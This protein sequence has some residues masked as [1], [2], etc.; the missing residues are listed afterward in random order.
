MEDRLKDLDIERVE[1][2]PSSKEFTSYVTVTDELAY[3]HAPADERA[4]LLACFENAQEVV[5]PDLLDN[6]AY[7]IAPKA[8]DDCYVITNLQ[9]P[10]CVNIIGENAFDD[11]VNLEYTMS[12]EGLAYIGNTSNPYLVLVKRFSVEQYENGQIEYIASN[13]TSQYTKKFTEYHVHADTKIIY[14]YALSGLDDS[15]VTKI[16][17][18]KGLTQIGA[19]AFAYCTTLRDITLPEGLLSIGE[20][21]FENCNALPKLTIP[22][23]VTDIDLNSFLGCSWEEIFYQEFAE[24]EAATETEET[25]EFE[26]IVDFEESEEFEESVEFEE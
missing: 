9:I 17:L 5:L 10:N 21:A 15:G 26:E 24:M 16:D 23:S 6:V 18:P 4:L 7:D 12:E 2:V 11:C 25:T 3:Y 14:H 19:G 20:R 1:R 13:I 8:F 22:K